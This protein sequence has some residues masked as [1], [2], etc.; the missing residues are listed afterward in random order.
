MYFIRMGSG[1]KYAKDL[2]SMLHIRSCPDHHTSLGFPLFFTHSLKLQ[3]PPWNVAGLL[4]AWN[5]NLQLLFDED[6][7]QVLNFGAHKSHWKFFKPQIHS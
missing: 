5:Q 7:P 3:S 1:E 6:R 2:I 4:T